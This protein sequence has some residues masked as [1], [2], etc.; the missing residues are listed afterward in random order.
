MATFEGVSLIVKSLF[1]FISVLH[2]RCVLGL[3]LY[4][5]SF[6]LLS[7]CIVVVVVFIAL[8]FVTPT[9]V[10]IQSK[11]LEIGF[12]DLNTLCQSIPND[13]VRYVGFSVGK[14]YD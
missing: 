12:V 6:S 2:F 14:I 7:S 10:T 8:F 11:T 4:F 1:F 5:F 3:V 9:C 13:S